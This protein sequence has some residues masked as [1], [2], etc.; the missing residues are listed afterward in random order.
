MDYTNAFIILDIDINEVSYSNLTLEYLKK[1]YKKMALKHHPDKNGNTPE[2]KEKFQQINEAYNFL[3][4]EMSDELN[5]DINEDFN[6]DNST[7]NYDTYFDFLSSFILSVIEGQ[8]SNILPSI[9]TEIINAGK[10]VSLKL[11]EE[12]DRETTLYIYNF[13]STYKSVFHLNPNIL[14]QIRNFLI[15]KYEKVS[16]YKLNP[17]IH[18]LINN[19]L[20]KLY[21]DNQLLLVPLWHNESHYDLSG[22]EII[23]ICEPEL[24]QGLE[25]D[26]DNNICIKK[27]IKMEDIFQEVKSKGECVIDVGVAGKIFSISVSKLFIRRE[28]VFKIK[29]AGLTKVK[30]DMYDI[31]DKTDIL[32]TIILS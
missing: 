23:V 9:I 8:H 10:N 5:M 3:K 15:S 12:L 19:N 16:V 22:N 11:F 32:V 14:E 31:S 4:R 17:S 30:K 26:E 13:L 7:D 20:Y 18:D 21:V 25:I 28:Q 29:N 24:D 6:E 2:S 1:Q 27:L